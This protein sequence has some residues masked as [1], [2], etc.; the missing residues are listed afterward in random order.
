LDPL[1]GAHH[2]VGIA[3][4]VLVKRFEEKRRDVHLG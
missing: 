3:F 1:C 2:V 4:P